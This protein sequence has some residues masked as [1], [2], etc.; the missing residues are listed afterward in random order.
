MGSGIGSS[1]FYEP[2]NLRCS[3]HRAIFSPRSL[4]TS[5]HTLAC[6]ALSCWHLRAQ[7]LFPLLFRLQ[8]HALVQS[9][10]KCAMT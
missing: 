8:P 4:A 9:S 1:S 3:Y 7:M 6:K 2:I 10:Y 5:R